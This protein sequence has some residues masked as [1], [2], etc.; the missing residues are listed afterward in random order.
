MPQ[1]MKGQ[2]G[3]DETVVD[4]PQLE[5]LLDARYAQLEARRQVAQAFSEADEAARAA[6]AELD[7][8]EGTALRIG[9]YRITKTTSAAR[10][11]EFDTEPKTRLRIGTDEYEDGE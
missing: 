9:A 4:N 11:V 3:M 8:A 1:R 5:Q 2:V 10:H 6:L 7:I